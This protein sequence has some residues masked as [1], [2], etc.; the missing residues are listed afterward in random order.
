M[1]RLPGRTDGSRGSRSPE[2][3]EETGALCEG[4]KVRGMEKVQSRQEWKAERL[5]VQEWG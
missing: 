4:Q 2:G 5:E 3:H 1:K